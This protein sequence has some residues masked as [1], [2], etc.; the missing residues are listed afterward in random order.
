MYT[1]IVQYGNG[2]FADA[3]AE[4]KDTDTGGSL[5][6]DSPLAP[7]RRAVTQ[8]LLEAGVLSLA[9]PFPNSSYHIDFY[10]PALKCTEFDR[11]SEV[12]KNQSA[13][14]F[15][16]SRKYPNDIMATCY[17]YLSWP[18]NAYSTPWSGSDW[19]MAFDITTGLLGSDSSFTVVAV[20]HA[21]E[22]DYGSAPDINLVQCDLWNASYAADFTYNNGVQDV[23]SSI[24]SYESFFE[25]TA[26]AF[27]SNAYPGMDEPSNYLLLWSYMSVMDSFR[28]YT[29]WSINQDPSQL[30]TTM[31]V[32]TKMID[33]ILPDTP[34]LNSLHRAIQ[35]LSTGNTTNLSIKDALEEMFRNAT[36]S[37]ASQELLLL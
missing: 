35:G 4:D 29:V 16:M 7:V 19:D 15:K 27:T 6:Y 30:D 9:A 28:D 37:L 36:L 25:W 34:Q 13:Q 20:S 31:F 17:Y 2:A 14:I 22:C 11:T 26:T 18:G 5:N 24:T 1:P 10:G 8:S 21:D 23:S 12:W 3:V 33:T 32:N